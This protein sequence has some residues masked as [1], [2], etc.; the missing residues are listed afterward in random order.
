M[1]DIIKIRRDLHQIPELG[2]KEFK[3]Q[4]Y[5]LNILK[6]Y[7]CS[8]TLIKTGI[9]AFFDNQKKSSLAY[10]SDM[11]GLNIQETNSVDYKSQ[12]N[13]HACGHDAHMALAIGLCDYLNEHYQEYSQNFVIIFQPSEESFGGSKLVI[14]S[15]ILDTYHVNKVIA[16]H[17][18]PK[19]P[20]G[21]FFTNKIVFSSAREI[22]YNFKGKSVHV[23]N[24]KGHINCIDV[25]YKFTKRIEKLS[26]KNTLVHI[27]MFSSGTS[28]NTVSSTTTLNGTIRSKKNDIKIYNKIGKIKERYEKR[29]HLKIDDTSVFLSRVENSRYLIKKAKRLI[30]LKTIKKTYFQGEDFSS[31]CQIYPCLFL[32]FGIGDEEYLHSSNFN[33][34]DSLLPQCLE[35]LIKLLSIA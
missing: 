27:G 6:N 14:D 16:I 23:A 3:T 22:N 26:N 13:M 34:D 15:K 12:N 1:I 11:D 4:K 21:K 31:Y 7:C 5:I 17:L 32:L 20:K 18:F 19:L 10:R 30:D 8:I 28:R 24:K 29:Y 33:F 2:F 9:I 25:G 35:Q